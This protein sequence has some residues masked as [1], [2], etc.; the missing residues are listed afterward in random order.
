[1][2]FRNAF[3]QAMVISLLAGAISGC[4]YG[5]NAGKGSGTQLYEPG[6]YA[7]HAAPQSTNS[8]RNRRIHS[9]SKTPAAQYKFWNLRLDAAYQRLSTHMDLADQLA[10]SSD[11]TRW[12]NG[13]VNACMRTSGLDDRCAIHLT[14]DRIAALNARP[15]PVPSANSAAVPAAVPA[16]VGAAHA[17]PAQLGV[18]VAPPAQPNAPASEHIYAVAVT[19]MPWIWQS[20]GWRSGNDK[21]CRR[22]HRHWRRRTSR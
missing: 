5:S 3:V 4:G 11:Q 6:S 8:Y 21:I 18:G 12:L 19:A 10:L 14:R 7:L 17:L 13:R 16:T 9:V 2:N 20:G 22:H 15:L 1:M